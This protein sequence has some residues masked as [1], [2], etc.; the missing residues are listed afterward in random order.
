MSSLSAKQP[1]DIAELLAEREEHAVQALLTL[2][3]EKAAAALYKLEDGLRERVMADLVGNARLAP[4]LN[5]LDAD[6]VADLLNGLAPE[7]AQELLLQLEHRAPV[8]RLLSY[9]VD[10]AGGIMDTAVLELSASDTPETAAEK[11]RNWPGKLDHLQEAY[12]IDEARRLVGRVNLL[13]LLVAPEGTPV[14]SLW[15]EEPESVTVDLDQEKV[16]NRMERYDLDSM[17]VVDEEGV[18]LGSVTL[19][20]AISVLKRESDEDMRYMG[21]LSQSTSQAGKI[22]RI[23]QG[24]LPWLAL[25]MVGSI[26]G[27]VV[28]MRFEAVLE[29]AA[30]LAAF[31]PLIAAT[32]GNAGIQSSTVT[33]QGL[34]TGTFGIKGLLPRMARELAGAMLNGLAVSLLV[35]LFLVALEW[36]SPDQFQRDQALFL[37]LALSLLAVIIIAALIGALVPTLLDRMGVDPAVA[38][39]PFITVSN[40]IVGVL[41]YFLVAS[42]L[43][44]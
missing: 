17:P 1:A 25:G 15:E 29:Q 24:R 5:T 38:T 7:Q 14:A 13:R 18:L 35:A 32:A 21:G 22:W 34:A 36:W 23:V 30:I 44:L 39:G 26:L 43:Y 27:A 4:M 6:E 41:I 28:I 37:T 42:W 20:D 19:T 8:A 16:V 11:L 12:V 40:D 9:P 3:A 2:P 33:V 31:I 10:T